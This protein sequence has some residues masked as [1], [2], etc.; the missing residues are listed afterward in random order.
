MTELRLGLA[1][2]LVA[3]PIAA[4]AEPGES[5]R[6]EW[7]AR[8]DA[9]ERLR[10]HPCGDFAFEPWAR[11]FL[12]GCETGME[13]RAADCDERLDWVTDRAAQCRVWKNWLLRN[14]NQRVRRDDIP[15]PPTRVR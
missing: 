15:E 12:S 13:A 4:L 9:H 1:L 2:A 5:W 11:A 7:N 10:D 14:H 8:V 6:D 3:L